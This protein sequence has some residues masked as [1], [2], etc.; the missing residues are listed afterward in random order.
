MARKCS[1]LPSHLR[2]VEQRHWEVC[3][4]GHVLASLPSCH[5]LGA[6]LGGV[7]SAQV[8]WFQGALAS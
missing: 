8:E 1:R 4:N 5:W 3:R 7:S 2:K 6:F